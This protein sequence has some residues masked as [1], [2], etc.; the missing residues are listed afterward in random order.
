MWMRCRH[1]FSNGPAEWQW[2]DLGKCKD[3]NAEAEELRAE[4]VTE[5]QWSEHY[6]GIE[7]ELVEQP[8]LDVLQKLAAAAAANAG[9]WAARAAELDALVDA[10]LI[11]AAAPG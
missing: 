8:P 10:A 5:Y 11:S 7:Y 9:R 3:P 4:N 2:D 1:K 6:R